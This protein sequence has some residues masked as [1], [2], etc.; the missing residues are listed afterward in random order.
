MSK[1]TDIKPAKTAM[2]QAMKAGQALALAKELKA[3]M[4]TDKAALEALCAV[5][6]DLGVQAADVS[7]GYIRAKP[8]D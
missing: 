5:V 4:G 3:A 8:N 1:S 7:R 2:G 6:I